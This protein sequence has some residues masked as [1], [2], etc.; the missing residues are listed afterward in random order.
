MSFYNIYSKYKDFDLEKFNNSITEYDIERILN[1]SKLD[2]L[3]FLA[4]LSPKACNSLEKM[5]QR[6]HSLTVQHFGKTIIIYTPM[7]LA[8]YCTNECVYCGFNKQNK[9]SRKQLSLEEV[10]EE[11]KFISSKGIK[12]I[13]ILTGDAREV[14]SV[15]YIRRCV[16][17]L[18]KYF[19]SISIEIYALEEDEY[20]TLVDAGVDSLTI[21]QETYNEELYDTL[22]L[23]GPKKDYRFRLDAPERSCNANIRNVNVGA[24]LGLDS[25]QKEA[26]LTGLHAKYIEEKFPSVEVSISM[27]RIRPS[28]GGFEPNVIVSDK[29]LVQFITASRLFINRAGIT[30]STRENSQFRDNVLPLGVT[31]MSADS[32]TSVG[33]HSQENS[34]SAQ[35]DISDNR[36]LD[37]M[38]SDI[39]KLGYQP[40]LKDWDIIN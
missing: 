9:L 34:D 30:I 35:F 20:K 17:I 27:P 29:N 13:L 40:V 12:H 31:K 16:T 4:L 33:G 3:D 15:D 8:N 6:S 32:N 25:F 7:Y 39:K 36:S 11:A 2:D 21:Y 5:A 24:L 19:N 10:E 18:K 37:D 22:H 26:F 14:S 1:K 23:S 38:L 28:V